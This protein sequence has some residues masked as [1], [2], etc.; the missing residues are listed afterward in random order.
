MA[1]AKAVK[2]KLFPHFTALT[3]QDQVLVPIEFF[4]ALVEEAVIGDGGISERTERSGVC[5]CVCEW[6]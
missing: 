4:F 1:Q 6:R 5:V 3:R 2:R